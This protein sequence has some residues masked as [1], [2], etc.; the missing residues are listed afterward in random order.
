M[1]P[2]ECFV[3]YYHQQG[4]VYW[5]C[6]PDHLSESYL[7]VKY[8]IVLIFFVFSNFYLDSALQKPLSWS[9]V[10]YNSNNQER[11]ITWK[12]NKWKYIIGQVKENL[13][14]NSLYKIHLAWILLS[15]K[16][17][18]NWFLLNLAKLSIFGQS[19]PKVGISRRKTQQIPK[20]TMYNQLNYTF[21]PSYKGDFL[22]KRAIFFPGS[23]PNRLHFSTTKRTSRHT[24]ER[25]GAQKT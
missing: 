22:Y 5:E 9:S 16:D 3:E 12:Q 7:V 21:T 10:P 23:N 15:Y 11:Y 14:W 13:T 18:P 24:D 19:K 4:M 1:E 8:Q 17:Q 20:K 2:G 6:Y 25:T